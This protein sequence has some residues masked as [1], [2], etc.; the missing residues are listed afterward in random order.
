[1]LP[2]RTIGTSF[3]VSF[4]CIFPYVVNLLIYKVLNLIITIHKLNEKW[5]RDPPTKTTNSTNP[6]YYWLFKHFETG[7]CCRFMESLQTYFEWCQIFSI[8][9]LCTNPLKKPQSSCKRTLPN[10][11]RLKNFP[12]RPMKKR[13]SS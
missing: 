7:Q 4:G 8:C 10:F 11:G 12:G 3:L 6:D 2:P 13:K 5:R 9:K 1:M